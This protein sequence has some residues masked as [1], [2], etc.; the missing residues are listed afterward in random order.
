MLS[1][2]YFLAKLRV[3]TVENEPAKKLHFLE[4]Q[5][6]ILLISTYVPTPA[7]ST[8]SLVV[9]DT[10]FNIARQDG[11]EGRGLIVST[12]VF[13]NSELERILSN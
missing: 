5:L 2:G 12:Y 1:N 3:D 13:S 10:A 7:G 9:T 6:L 11:L 4:K 8:E